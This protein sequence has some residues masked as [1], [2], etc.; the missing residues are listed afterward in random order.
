MKSI[1]MALAAAA[2]LVAFQPGA[3]LSQQNS[4]NNTYV[5]C[6][7]A[8]VSKTVKSFQERCI[9]AC[10]MRNNECS[11][12]IYGARPRQQPVTTAQQPREA[13]EALARR[14]AAPAP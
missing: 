13:S 12:K 14:D 1:T 4:C 9:E 8:C 11:E 6:I 2:A 5:S 10:Q 3:A 7:D